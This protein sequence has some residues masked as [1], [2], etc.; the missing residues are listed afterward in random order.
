MDEV[1]SLLAAADPAQE[2]APCG[3]R[4]LVLGH[5]VLEQVG[6]IVAGLLG[7]TSAGGPRP[8]VALLV[9]RTRIVR[10]GE[11]VKDLVE[12]LLAARFD[13]T[14][15]VLD[16][17]HAE[18]HVVDHVLDA[19]T[20]AATGAHAVIALGG[21]TI[22]DIGKVAA[23]RTAEAGA[24]PVLVTVATAASVDGYTDDVS[25]VIRDGVKRTVPSRWPDAVIADAS[26]IA[27]APAAMNRAGYGEMTSMLTAPADWT[28]AALVGFGERFHEAP[29]RLLEA[30]GE[31]VEVWSSGVGREEPD[32]VEQLTRVLT[33]R[34]IVTGVAGTTAALSGVEHL[35]SHMLDLHHA[36]HGLP[37]G[38][39]GAQVGVAGLVAA[40]AWEMLHERMATAATPPRLHRGLLDPR[41]ARQRV[42][43]AF[44]GLDVEGRIAEECWA[45]YSVKLA[46]VDASRPLFEAVLIGWAKHA[47]VLRS[48]VRSTCELAA[49]LRAAGAAATFDQLDPRVEPDLARWAVGHCALMRNRFTVVDL[50]TFLGWWGP[51]D[52]E[53]VLHRAQHAAVM[54]TDA[55]ET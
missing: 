51:D 24:A 20:T 21:G 55:G 49:G 15:T 37:V 52:V 34:G 30:C 6:E 45:D 17:G 38:L 14:R 8:R 2:L 48:R 43:D 19:A 1:R 40:A 25:V 36:A 22:S 46:A 11:D 16:D 39:H 29:L 28:L 7:P 27:E 32:A 23:Q 50:L 31:G 26:L 47:P 4:H 54:A 53:E 10:A 42:M 18:L 33:I 41:R 5:E 35:V 13:V 3:L 44:A 12:A 9:D